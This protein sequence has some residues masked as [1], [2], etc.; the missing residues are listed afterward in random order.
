[1]PEGEAPAQSVLRP[2]EALPSRPPEP[3]RARRIRRRDADRGGDM[4]PSVLEQRSS[5]R[6]VPRACDEDHTPDRG[7][8][9]AEQACGLD[10]VLPSIVG[11]ALAENARLGHA[12]GDEDA[13]DGVGL[14]RTRPFEAAA[15][16]DQRRVLGEEGVARGLGTAPEGCAAGVAAEDAQ[17]WSH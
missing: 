8:T 14:D 9:L 1:E 7:P 2:G 3:L 6:D 11:T 16:D 13:S 15:G 4:E 12:P 10:R 5:S 17:R